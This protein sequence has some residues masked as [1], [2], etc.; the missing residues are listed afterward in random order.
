MLFNSFFHVSAGFFT[1]VAIVRDKCQ[2]IHI[3]YQAIDQFN[4]FLHIVMLFQGSQVVAF[5]P[6]LGG[7]AVGFIQWGMREQ[8][9][10]GSRQ[11]VTG[12][13]YDHRNIFPQVVK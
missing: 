2:A 11:A 4:G 7:D 12:V 5:S 8:N 10:Q 1:D 13:R 3:R 6:F 9:L